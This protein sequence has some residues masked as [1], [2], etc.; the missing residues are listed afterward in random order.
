VKT[1]HVSGGGGALILILFGLVTYAV[2]WI[3]NVCIKQGRTG[4]TIG[5]GVLAIRLLGYSGQPIGAGL[6]FVRQLAHFLDSI[7]C[8]VGWL[9]PLWD[10]RK[11]TFADKI[12]ST[13]VVNVSSP[14]PPT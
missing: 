8:Y 5:K 9:W 7:A 10:A 11:Q 14:G 2:F 12:M 13:V 3:W 1:T 4:A 6:S